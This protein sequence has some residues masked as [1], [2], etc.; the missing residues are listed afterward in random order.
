MKLNELFES[1][2]LTKKLSMLGSSDLAKFTRLSIFIN[3]NYD[4]FQDFLNSVKQ[5]E[6]DNP[7]AAKKI[8]LSGKYNLLIRYLENSG[9]KSSIELVPLVSINTNQKDIN[10]YA[11]VR[12]NSIVLEDG[13]TPQFLFRFHETRG[14][15]LANEHGFLEPSE[16]YK[17]THASVRPDSNYKTKDTKLLVIEYNTNDRWSPKEASNGIIY[18]T[19]YQ[20]IPISR[21]KIAY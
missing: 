10:F 16:F 11:S 12:Q 7:E 5:F 1:V 15:D 3:V 4:S 13:S 19:T 17:R 20:K 6:A 14:I 9:Y 8:M 2:S 18:A 21:I